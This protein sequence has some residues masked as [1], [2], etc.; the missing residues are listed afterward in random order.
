VPSRQHRQV[1][2]TEDWH[3]LRF[4]FTWAEQRSYELIRPVVLFGRSPAE[5]AKETG[6][7]ARTIYRKV[8]R[9]DRLGMLG[10]FT[11]EPSHDA[12]L[13]PPTIRRAI[14]ELKAEHPAFRPHE[15]ATICFIRFDRR[16]SSHTIRRI[17]AEEPL[18]LS[19]PRRFPPYSQMADP[20][21][22]RLAIVQLHAE[23]WTVSSIARY[24]QTN[25]ARVY[26]TLR[27]WIVE[28]VEGL[29]DKSHAPKQPARK[30]NLAAMDAIR[31]LQVNPELGEFRL[32]AALL[33]L[34]IKL[35]PRT[36]GRVL[37]LNRRLYG[38][39]GPAKVPHEPQMM[40]FKA[41]RRHQYWTVDLRYL[42]HQLDDQ[43]VYCIS[44]LENYSR[45]VLASAISRTQDLTAYL[46]VLF[47][48]IRQHGAPEVIVSDSGGIFLAKEAQRIYRA[49][50]IQKRQI[51]RGQAWQ[52]YI[53]TTFNIQRRMADWYFAQATTWPELR[54]THDRWVADYNYQVHWA[55][56]E[57]EDQRHSPAA[58]LGW[59]TGTV[60]ADEELRRLFTVRFRRRLDRQGYVRFR[61]WRI[62]G[63]RGLA[64]DEGAVWLYGENLTVHF[65][66][67]PLAQYKVAYADAGKR[68]RAVGDPR[69]FE[70]PFQ[71]PQPFLWERGL[72]DWHLVLRLPEYAPRRR[73]RTLAVQPLLFELNA[74]VLTVE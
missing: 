21:E 74:E 26:K 63:E 39:P 71:S 30:V 11:E 58:V 60:Y 25:R 15:L 66:E 54:K 42:D 28:G 20:T 29:R 64:R 4:H 55:H 13:L 8:H 1:A 18:P 3:Q 6:A 73:K 57:R 48:A 35:S 50:D 47:A 70:T 5:R 69:L 32:H 7:A 37:A 56:R 10:L 49:L 9:F 34:G 59:V 51:D 16:P 53:E 45:A 24:L 36:C 67:E 17:L 52:S 41:V 68:L 27:R 62:Y 12:R 14:V 38:L 65:A 22:R 33:Q 61:H 40:P 72:A 43:N 46:I 19:V 44:I 2:P 31:K 23:G